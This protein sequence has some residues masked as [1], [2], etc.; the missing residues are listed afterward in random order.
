MADFTFGG[1]ANPGQCYAYDTPQQL[2][3]SW[4]NVPFFSA[5][6]PGYTGSNTFQLILNKGDSTITMQ[7][8]GCSGLNGSNG[9]VVGIESITGDIG[10]ARTQSLAPSTGSSK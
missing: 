3:V 8:Q 5:S 2:V 6:S 7:Y 4:I 1:V 10:L 9:P